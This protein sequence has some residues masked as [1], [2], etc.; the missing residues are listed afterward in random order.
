[1]PNQN[2]RER[3]GRSGSHSS[4]MT[5]EEP[6]RQHYNQQQQQQRSYY[7]AGIMRSGNNSKTVDDADIAAGLLQNPLQQQQQQQ[8][9]VLQAPKS[10]DAS[11]VV[12]FAA[13][14]PKS[15]RS[16]IM[17]APSS[18]QSLASLNTRPEHH[19]SDLEFFEDLVNDPVLLLG[20]DISHLDRRSQFIVC[21]TG[22]FGFSLLY[23]Y[24]QELIS[25]E[26]CNRQ[27]GLFLAMM[28]FSGYTLLAYILRNFVYHQNL[29]QVSARQA[30]NASYQPPAAPVVPFL[31]YLG[32]SLLRAID[33]GMT[34]L[35]M[36]Y[37]NYPAKTLMKSSR[38]VFTMLFGVVIARKVYK[39]VDYVIVMGMVAGLALFMHAD[40]NSSAVFDWA[41]VAMLTV[42]LLCDGAISNMS[43][44]IMNRYGVGQDEFIFRMYSIALVAITIVAALKGDL[45]E[46]LIFMSQPG[47][48]GPEMSLPIE[49]RTWSVPGKVAVMVLFS[50]M[51][52]FGSSCSAA[53]TKN[54]GALTMSITSTARKAT[55]LFL[56][57]FLFHNVCTLEHLMGVF[58]FIS[59]LTA[60]SL[61]RGDK[62][63]KR[64]H[65][66]HKRA[67]RSNEQRSRDYPSSDLETRALHHGSNDAGIEGAIV[68]LTGMEE[69]HRRS[70]SPPSSTVSNLTDSPAIISRAGRRQRKATSA[71][72]SPSV[73]VL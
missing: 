20:V 68:T 71:S 24:L 22:V 15:G 40:A 44:T 14:P 60:K 12:G 59:S 27:L 8:Q 38:V 50:S 65:R 7:P 4:V 5:V 62:K 64:H 6:P 58:I 35:A 36:Q 26:L 55:T 30:A 46:G 49:Q 25:V 70:M 72:A 23:G 18:L 42:S 54:F 53:I 51:G 69:G 16:S 39:T 21:A 28:Q 63:N 9:Q 73:Q 45:R 47:S 43:E 33:L 13:E 31:L 61:R 66:H 19:P 3:H 29:R 32:L 17:T 41:G 67:K 52:F 2:M 11:S 48:Y 10:S 56:S 57:F 37:I 1:M 34:N